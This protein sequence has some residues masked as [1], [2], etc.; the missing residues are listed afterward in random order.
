MFPADWLHRPL[1]LCPHHLSF[2]V[3]TPLLFYMFSIIQQIVVH[4]S[5]YLVLSMPSSGKLHEN[6][7][8]N[9]MI[10]YLRN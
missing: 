4:L 8:L 6:S 2:I 10:S 9:A 3:C 5:K 1:Q 7:I